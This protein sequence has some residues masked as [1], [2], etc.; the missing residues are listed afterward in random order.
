[1]TSLTDKMEGLKGKLPKQGGYLPK[2]IGWSLAI[3]ACKALAE[4][5]AATQLDH[6][7][8]CNQ[9]TIHRNDK[10]LKH[11]AAVVGDWEVEFDKR[12]CFTVP[13]EHAFVGHYDTGDDVEG[14]RT[15][16]WNDYVIKTFIRDLLAA[17][18]REREEAV[19]ETLQEVMDWAMANGITDKKSFCA[20]RDYLTE[21][22]LT[23]PTTL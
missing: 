23:S 21:K 8:V 15:G 9:M 3:D 20:L 19:T 2:S 5:E 17:K 10:C 12:F 1:M 11:K 18:D 16:L 22:A 14:S 6:C 7:E 13:D 4:A